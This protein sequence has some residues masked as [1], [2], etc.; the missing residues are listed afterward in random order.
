[1]LSLSTPLQALLLSIAPIPEQEWQWLQA[2]LKE[3]LFAPGDVLFSQGGTDAGIHYLLY[4]LVRYF[5]LTE[6]G[7]ERNHTFAT[8]GNLTGC[9]S[10]FAGAGPCNFTVESIEPTRSLEI[11]SAVFLA[12]DDRHPCWLRLKLKLAQHVAL[13]KEAREAGFLL[14]SAETRYRR[15]LADYAKLADRIPLYHIASWLGI[16]P[17]AL[18]RIRRR[19]NTG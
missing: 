8:E 3:R 4:G 18:S 7:L 19:L 10:T 5:Y 15:F 2:R 17:V 14:D 12:L 13:R 6:N 11:P 16:T 1:M 9:L